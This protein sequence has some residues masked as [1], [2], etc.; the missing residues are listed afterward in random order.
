MKRS[1][2]YAYFIDGKFVGW[3]AD[4]FGSVRPQSPKLY[5]DME[6]QNP[7]ILSS[8]RHKLNKINTSSFDQAKE[9]VTNV[10]QAIGLAGYD[11][12][13][14][15]RGRE[16]ILKIVESPIYDGPNP[17]FDEEA[18]IALNEERRKEMKAE[19]IFD[20]PAP[21]K[22][23]VA[24]IEEFDTRHARPKADNW[25]YADY[26]KVKEWAATEPTVFLGEIDPEKYEITLY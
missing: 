20:I 24:A 3:Y 18:Y 5:S 15:L 21:S 4:S 6:K 23:R 14:L 11:S 2:C 26:S 8:L 12:E 22:E 25:I 7:V 19:G 9:K 10:F 13:E 1:I 16:V 17:D